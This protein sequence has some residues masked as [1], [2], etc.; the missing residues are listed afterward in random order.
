MMRILKMHGHSAIQVFKNLANTCYLRDF[1]SSMI[2]FVFLAGLCEST[3]FEKLM[4][5]A[6]EGTWG[7]TRTS[8]W[9][10]LDIIGLG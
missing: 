10:N 7:E 1:Y 5:K 2:V 8:L 4:V 9:S 6:W 3:L